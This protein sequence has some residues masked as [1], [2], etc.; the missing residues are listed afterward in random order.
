MFSDAAPRSESVDAV[1]VDR[2]LGAGHGVAVVERRRCERGQPALLVGGLDLL[3]L[4]LP[5]VGRLGRVEPENRLVGRPDVLGVTSI[6]PSRIALSAISVL[7][8]LVTS[9]A[10]PWASSAWAYA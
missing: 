5:G 7:A 2:L 10:K 9:E 8:R 4:G 3:E 6:S 1:L